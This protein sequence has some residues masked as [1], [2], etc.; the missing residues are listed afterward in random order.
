MLCG[1][2]Y[3]YALTSSWAIPN[4]DSWS[5]RAAV[6]YSW[7]AGCSTSRKGRLSATVTASWSRRVR[8]S[9]GTAP[10]HG[11]AVLWHQPALEQLT[12]LSIEPT[13]DHRSRMHI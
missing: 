1:R 5:A 3:L 9:R 10:R 11:L 7:V 6:R 12:G 13:R 4:P 8:Q 2:Q